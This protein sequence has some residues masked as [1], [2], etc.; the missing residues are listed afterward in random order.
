MKITQF[1]SNVLFGQKTFNDLNAFI[2]ECYPDSDQYTVYVIDSVHRTTGLYD[3]LQPADQDMVM[4][5]D[6]RT[7]NLKQGIS[8]LFATPLSSRKATR[9]HGLWWASVA[10]AP[11]MWPKRSPFC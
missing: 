2:D 3:R 11:W 1:V 5:F 4:E 8:M 9:R 6:A 10:A 7:G